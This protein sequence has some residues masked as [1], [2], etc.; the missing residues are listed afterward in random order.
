MA[1][2][3]INS[4]PTPSCVIC[5]EDVPPEDLFKMVITKCQH[6]YH[7]QCLTGWIGSQE[8]GTKATCPSC[9]DDIKQFDRF[10]EGAGLCDDDTPFID[11]DIVKAV[12][13]ND[14]AYLDDLLKLSSS[15]KEGE[16]LDD[17]TRQG[18]AL[19]FAVKHKDKS[20]GVIM[21]LVCLAAGYGHFELTQKLVHAGGDVNEPDEGGMTPLMHALLSGNQNLAFWLIENGA[22]IN[23]TLKSGVNA[24][25]QAA[26]S[27]SNK[28]L[29]YLID[30]GV[31]LN[32]ISTES[33][34][35]VM[36]AAAEG[37]NA[38]TICR[39][40]MARVSVDHLTANN[41][42]PL[43]SAAYSRNLA[44]AEQL[45]NLKARVDVRTKK[46]NNNALLDAVIMGHKE[47]VQLLLEKGSDPNVVTTK[48]ETPLMIAARNGDIEITKLLLKHNANPK[49]KVLDFKKRWLPFSAVD[50]AFE[51]AQPEIYELMTGK[52]LFKDVPSQAASTSTEQGWELEGGESAAEN[53]TDEVER[54][55]PLSCQLI[56][57][58][59]NF[60]N[61]NYYK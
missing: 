28:V 46:Q 2:P 11:S 10:P 34:K 47:L 9:R 40:H 45:L 37:G 25:F 30:K 15:T 33:K 61:P 56:S 39:L 52:P 8:P 12:K 26:K 27:G 51:K 41:L 58:T 4:Q 59:S 57:T 55:S 24:T 50:V 43:H 29:Q 54:R 7:D 31:N 20:T 16:P 3:N 44:T 13:K 5:L 36:H 53:V 14:I 6:T 35:G 23:T 19:A 42:T 18:K 38:E 22:D 60:V 49:Q 21:P 17:A 48:K 1:T 32:Y